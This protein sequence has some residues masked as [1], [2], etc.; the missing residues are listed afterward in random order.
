MYCY[1]T[2][3]TLEIVSNM[4]IFDK[5]D[6]DLHS[7]EERQQEKESQRQCPALIRKISSLLQLRLNDEEQRN[8]PVLKV[9]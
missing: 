5:V 4:Q 6:S 9:V 1:R 2:S 3:N 7:T 8:D